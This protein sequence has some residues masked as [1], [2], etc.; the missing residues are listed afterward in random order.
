MEVC[1]VCKRGDLGNELWVNGLQRSLRMTL[2]L[3]EFSEYVELAFSS[4]RICLITAKNCDVIKQLHA[5]K[6][7]GV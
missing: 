6:N 4:L 5:G 3:G 2:Y 7:T 1:I